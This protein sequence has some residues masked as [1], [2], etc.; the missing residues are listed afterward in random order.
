MKQL[1]KV[2][3][4]CKAAYS[5]GVPVIYLVTDNYGLVKKVA[6]NDSMVELYY[7]YGEECKCRR[8][9]LEAGGDVSVISSS[10]PLNLKESV[11]CLSGDVEPVETASVTKEKK[12][13]M[14][15]TLTVKKEDSLRIAN[16]E[17]TVVKRTEKGGLRLTGGANDGSGQDGL[18]E[19]RLQPAIRVVYNFGVQGDN[20]ALNAYIKNIYPPLLIQL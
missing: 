2:I 13:E 8:E 4:G 9:I 10:A 3:E 16:V 7:Q 18:S 1:E 17:R 12:P 20:K 5:S 19:T 11:F 14:P 6:E 15:L